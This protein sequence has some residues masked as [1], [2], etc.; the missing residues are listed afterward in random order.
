M[1]TAA[2]ASGGIAVFD[3]LLVLLSSVLGGLV[4]CLGH[5]AIEAPGR[6]GL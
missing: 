6:R 5:R 4:V 1:A 3:M 2:R